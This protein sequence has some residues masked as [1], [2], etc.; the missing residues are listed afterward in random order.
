MKTQFDL[1]KNG[2]NAQTVWANPT[3]KEITIANRNS[4]GYNL[5]C[6]L[7]QDF[8]N[9]YGIHLKSNQ[10]KGDYRKFY[11]SA[12]QLESLGFKLVKRGEKPL[13]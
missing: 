12:K 13:W 2:N 5:L 8:R 7:D 11:N 4:F 6:G 1:L 3:I 10:G 9:K